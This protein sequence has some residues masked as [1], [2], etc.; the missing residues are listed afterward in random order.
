MKEQRKE[1]NKFSHFETPEELEKVLEKRERIKKKRKD[2][3][4]DLP[5]VDELFLK[6]LKKI[7]EDNKNER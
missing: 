1:I 5:K 3:I 4:E 7:K 2:E 6:Q